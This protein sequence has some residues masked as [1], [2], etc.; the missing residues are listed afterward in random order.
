VTRIIL[1]REIAIK[2]VKKI[3]DLF[4][5]MELEYFVH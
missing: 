3:H 5:E 4:P 2:E 1:A